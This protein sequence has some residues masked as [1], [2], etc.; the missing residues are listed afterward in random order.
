MLEMKIII[1]LRTK[2][3][4]KNSNKHLTAVIKSTRYVGLDNFLRFETFS[5]VVRGGTRP[6][7]P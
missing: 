2:K 6:I 4:M 3:G 5:F 7:N 1:A